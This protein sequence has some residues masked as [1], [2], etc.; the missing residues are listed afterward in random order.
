[1]KGPKG[2]MKLYTSTGTVDSIEKC[3]RLNVGL[4]MV[5]HW[6]NPDRWPY[7]AI[8]NG[9][10]SAYQR[11]VPWDASPFMKILHRCRTENRIPDFIVLPDKVANP[12]SLAFSKVW[13]P[14]MESMY[15]E[16]PR[17]LAV[18]N[19]MEPSKLKDEIDI[20]RIQG[21]FVGGTMDWKLENLKIWVT[22]AHSNGLECHVGR[23]GPIQRMLLCEIA[24]ADS[25]DST[26]W[27]QRKGGVKRYIG[28]YSAQKTLNVD[29][30]TDSI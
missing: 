16:F 2:T 12:E 27:V 19:G 10:Y 21:I 6:R 20:N 8:D 15:P 1:M 4:L 3:N 30:I 28:G 14:V 17:Y 5:A 9:C 11:G 23:I 26:T 7:F 25:I 22:F 18:Q 24:G 13:L 29:S